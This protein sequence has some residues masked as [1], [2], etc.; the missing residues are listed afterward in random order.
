M[1][2]RIKVTEGRFHWPQYKFK[3]WPFWLNYVD[4]NTYINGLADMIHNPLRFTNEED[5]IEYVDKQKAINQKVRYVN[6]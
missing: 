1:K 5:A 2:Y 3:F 4:H 6:L